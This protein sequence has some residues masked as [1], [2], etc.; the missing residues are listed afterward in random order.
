MAGAI[1][2]PLLGFAAWSG[3]G[4]TTLLRHVIL[5]LSSAGLRVGLVKHAHHNF[6]I[7]HPGK[8]SY[9][10]R[11]AG[12]VRVAVASRE[13]W[14]LMVERHLESDPSLTDLVAAIGPGE[15]DLVL[16]EGFRHEG[17]PKIEI[18]RPSLG[19]PLLFPDDPSVVA[20]ATDGALPIPTALPVLDLN[21]PA[22]IAGFVRSFL[23]V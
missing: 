12:A 4:K 17:L 7:D 1:T 20:V 14:A 3:V 5:I 6:D 8:D 22:Q 21:R 15:L 9:E 10:L 2:V 16:V 23:R 11:R 19:R 18:H 13:R